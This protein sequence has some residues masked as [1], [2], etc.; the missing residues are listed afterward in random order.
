M[1]DDS[2]PGMGGDPEPPSEAA[3]TVFIP[4]TGGDSGE[5][6]T[7]YIDL[8]TVFAEVVEGLPAGS[9]LFNPA[10]VMKQG[11]VYEVEVRISPVSAEEIEQDEEIIATLTVGMPDEQPVVVIPLKVSTV[12]EAR[13]TGEA[14][15]ITPLTKEE[16][17]RTSDKPYASWKW[18]VRPEKPGLQRLTLHLSVVVNAEGMGDKTHT[19][20]DVRVVDVS[21]NLLYLVGRF[22]GSN[23]EWVATGVVLPFLGWG[24]GKIRGRMKG[25]NR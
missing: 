12:M 13:L 8:N 11:K 7:V 25:M 10:K 19:V 1:V 17:I 6:E 23:W 9:A 22:M 16:Q 15:T 21:S 18:E 3:P 24:V 2:P 20:S 5:T 14:F 4:V